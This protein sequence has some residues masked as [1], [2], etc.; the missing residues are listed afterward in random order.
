M[1]III[2]VSTAI[3]RYRWWVLLLFRMLNISSIIILL[4]NSHLGRHKFK[5]DFGVYHLVR[6]IECHELN[7]S[8][9]I[10]TRGERITSSNGTLRLPV[11]I[12][13]FLSVQ[14]LF[15]TKLR[16]VYASRGGTRTIIRFFYPV[17][18][19]KTL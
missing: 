16:S 14:R 11:R 4:I 17:G 2:L 12:P 8:Q 19:I 10:A 9:G 15:V 13:L 5:I 7:S 18:Y 3:K 1:R 6:C